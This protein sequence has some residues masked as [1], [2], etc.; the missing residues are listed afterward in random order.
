MRLLLIAASILSFS[1]ISC[2]QDQDIAIK[3]VP[4]VVANAFKM[5][6]TNAT[7]VEWEQSNA[8]YEVEF[9]QDQVEYNALLDA[10]GNVIM[11][12]NDIKQDD[13]PQS[14]MTAIKT[15]FNGQK[16][17]ETE[18]L[19]KGNTTYYQVEFDGIDP[20]EFLFTADGNE[21]KEITYWD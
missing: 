2:G 8:N 10:E 17:D 21:T 18:K 5:Q 20:S 13:L 14:V 19:T 4:A 1:I 6:F 16:I 12:K 11:Y 7:D 3:D 15:N 9:T